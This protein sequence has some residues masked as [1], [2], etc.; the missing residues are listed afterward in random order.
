MRDGT[1]MG[2]SGMTAGR[3]DQSDVWAWNEV[4]EGSR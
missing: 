2:L 4:R 3:N 1:G